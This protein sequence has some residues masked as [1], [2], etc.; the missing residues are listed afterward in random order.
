VA[1]HRFVFIRH[2]QAECNVLGDDDLVVSCG[3]DAPLTTLGYTQAQALADTLPAALR[4]NSIHCSP[5]R[6][7]RQTAQALVDRHGLT[8]RPDA[9]LEELRL[10]EPLPQSLRQHAWDRL[11]EQRVATP[12]AAV[13]PGVEPLLEQFERVTDFLH[14]RHRQRGSEP[15]TLVVSHA[16]TIEL[17]LLALL[18]LGLDALG[19]FRFRLSNTGVHVVENDALGEGSRLLMVNALQHLGRW[20]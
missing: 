11:L 6:R 10:R 16:F 2:A 1:L 18:G 19:E 20:V 4:A 7:A 12:R 17:A 9:R 3:T 5:M 13:L 15:V 14:D 8:L